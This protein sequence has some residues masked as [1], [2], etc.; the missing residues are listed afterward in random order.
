MSVFVASSAYP[1][2]ALA[3]L[4]AVREPR[5]DVEVVL[6]FPPRVTGAAEMDEL[7]ALRAIVTATVGYDHVDVDAARERGIL[8]CN[9]P[10]YCVDEVADHT[11]ALLYALVRGIVALDRD[12]RAGDRPSRRAASTWPRGIDSN[13]ARKISAK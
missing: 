1:E 4:D 3:G 13:P 5:D 10:D 2:D 11:L 12:V 6:T 9:V 7:P 8:V